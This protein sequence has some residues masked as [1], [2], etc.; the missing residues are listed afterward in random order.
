MVVWKH[1]HW[2]VHIGIDTEVEIDKVWNENSFYSASLIVN[3]EN[4]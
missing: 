1:Q 4:I 2:K 3:M